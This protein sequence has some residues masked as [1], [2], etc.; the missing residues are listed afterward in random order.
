M[1]N[2][3][4]ASSRAGLDKS[5]SVSRQDFT[6][7]SSCSKCAEM[8]SFTTDIASVVVGDAPYQLSFL[9]LE[10]STGRLLRFLLVAYLIL[11]AEK[12]EL[13][14]GVSASRSRTSSLSFAPPRSTKQK[15]RESQ[16]F[17]GQIY[18]ANLPDLCQTNEHG[19]WIASLRYASPPVQHQWPGVEQNIL[20][21]WQSKRHRAAAHWGSSCSETFHHHSLALQLAR[22]TE[23]N[24]I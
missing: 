19:V 16:T 8:G 2:H 22:V 6:E 15:A 5:G 10:R 12:A 23:E 18:Y 7:Q 21:A 3:L 24:G 17:D 14:K 11:P 9:L 20:I 1:N 13:S 4:T